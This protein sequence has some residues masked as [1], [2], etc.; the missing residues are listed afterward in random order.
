MGLESAHFH[1]TVSESVSGMFS[2]EHQNC[3][4][5]LAGD[6]HTFL[7]KCVPFAECLVPHAEVA[8]WPTMLV[9]NG[10]PSLVVT[11]DQFVPL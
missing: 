4:F 11:Y 5:I 9:L 7:V 6:Q 8:I 2:A 1:L 3:V 10:R